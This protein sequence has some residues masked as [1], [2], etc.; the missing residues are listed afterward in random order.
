[1]RPEGESNEVNYY[2]RRCVRKEKGKGHNNKT[3]PY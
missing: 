3:P 2:R 1:V